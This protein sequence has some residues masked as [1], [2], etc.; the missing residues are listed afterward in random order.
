MDDLLETLDALLTPGADLEPH[1]PADA[2]I[3]RAPTVVSG[4]SGLP[5]IT[6][7]E[8]AGDAGAQAQPDLVIHEV[9][10]EGGMGVVRLAHQGS[11]DRYVAIKQVRGERG[12]AAAR[13][14]L[15]EG[16]V[17]GSL[18]HP[19]IIPVHALGRDAAGRPMIVMKLVD[20]ISWRA[21][22]RD[23]RH[24][25]WARWVGAREDRQHHHVEILIEVCKALR[26]AHQRGI[27]HRDLKPENVML[28]PLGAVYLLDWGVAARAGSPAEGV[29]G[30]PAYMAPEMLE[31]GAVVSEAADIYLLGSC[32]YEVLQGRPRHLGAD[33][34]A[35]LMAA[36][37]SEA[38]RFDDEVS[39][40]L[41]GICE[42]A[43]RRR[44]GDRY[45]SVDAFQAALVEYLRHQGSRAL[46]DAARGRLA[47]ARAILDAADG[48]PEGADGQR[49]AALF[50][51]SRFGLRHALEE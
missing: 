46:S 4:L 17:M 26:Y 32:L 20:G 30:T 48:A 10:G 44:P 9:L 13:M 11:L 39:P 15:H 43:G 1:H 51:E 31:R 18:E 36:W 12:A 23:P 40:E 45:P 14:L 8:V 28:D 2:T 6:V 38:P 25:G 27:V 24:P 16:R 47:R 34:R 29:A 19:N 50:A 5:W 22:I 21:L 33:L 41:A 37:V 7:G 3:R 42:R 35:V 49:A